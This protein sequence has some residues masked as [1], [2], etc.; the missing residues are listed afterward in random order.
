MQAE[1]VVR[2]GWCGVLMQAEALVLQQYDRSRHSHFLNWFPTSVVHEGWSRGRYLAIQQAILRNQRF[3]VVFCRTLI[4]I[5]VQ[6]LAFTLSSKSLGNMTEDCLEMDQWQS[7]PPQFI[8]HILFHTENL[9]YLIHTQDENDFSHT[10]YVVWLL[11][12]KWNMLYCAIY[13]MKRLVF[14][15][16]VNVKWHKV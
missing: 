2:L 7:N 8:S 9:I 10:F 1:A 12:N 14:D 3:C 16:H 11:L 13:V 4:H 5:S 15:I 6:D